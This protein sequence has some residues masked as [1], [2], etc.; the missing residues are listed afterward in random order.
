MARL[1][2]VLGIIINDKI[3]NALS[4]HLE[5]IFGIKLRYLGHVRLEHYGNMCYIL[6]CCL[7]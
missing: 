6:L 5:V 1:L 2:D 7:K 4:P 3:Y